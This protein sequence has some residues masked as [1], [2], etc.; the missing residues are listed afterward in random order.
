MPLPSHCRT[1]C[2]RPHAEADGARSRAIS[3]KMSANMSLEDKGRIVAESTNARPRGIDL[4]P[5]V[6]EEA[7]EAL[8]VVE[9]VAGC[10]GDRLFGR[11][12]RERSFEASL[13]IG[14]LARRPDRGGVSS[15][16][17]PR[18]RPTCAL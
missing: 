16:L 17:I 8:P 7:F 3:D 15:H 14:N 2:L 4:D 12:A 11:G 6:L 13:Q 1:C 9:A 18:F 5:S 10:D